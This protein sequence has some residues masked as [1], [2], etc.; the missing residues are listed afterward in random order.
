MKMSYVWQ[1]IKGT[2][3]SVTLGAGI[4]GIAIAA[5]AAFITVAPYISIPV[6][7]VAGVVFG[8]FGMYSSHRDYKRRVAK[9]A[10]KAAARQQTVAANIEAKAAVQRIDMR[11]KEIERNVVTMPLENKVA[12]KRPLV[13]SLSYDSS[14]LFSRRSM[15]TINTTKKPTRAIDND[16]RYGFGSGSQLNW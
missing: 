13:R 4:A 10:I 7:V 6:I 8:A 5:V 14:N 15:N 9:D 12:A 16:R 3:E 11:L 1:L 2:A